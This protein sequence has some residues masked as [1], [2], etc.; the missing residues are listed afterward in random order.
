MS[1]RAAGW[2]VLLGP[3]F[4]ARACLW[5][6][7]PAATRMAWPIAGIC[8]LP[9]CHPEMQEK[10]PAS[11]CWVAWDSEMLLM[12]SVPKNENPRVGRGSC[13]QAG[14]AEKGGRD[15]GTPGLAAV[16]L[17]VPL[18]CPLRC[19]CLSSFSC[20]GDQGP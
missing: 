9:C 10:Q 13:D 3:H 7:S 18:Q 12:H 4:L 15:T 16:G 20:M 1:E 2:T 14:W 11:P 6:S 5:V 17:A 8:G 19:L